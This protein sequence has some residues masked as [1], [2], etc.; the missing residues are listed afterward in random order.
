[1]RVKI[2]FSHELNVKGDN[3][4]GW[5]DLYNIKLINGGIRLLQNRIRTANTW[6]IDAGNY[7]ES[8]KE[9]SKMNTITA[10]MYRRIPVIKYFGLWFPETHNSGFMLDLTRKLTE[11]K[12]KLNTHLENE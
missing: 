6:K 8:R 2:L 9:I 4:R 5:Y 12:T 11:Y 3:K 10:W 1:M 7:K